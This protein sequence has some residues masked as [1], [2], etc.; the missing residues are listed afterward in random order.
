GVAIAVSALALW[1]SRTSLL[2]ALIMVFSAAMGL[3]LDKEPLRTKISLSSL[4]RHVI[5]Y[6]ALVS[7]MLKDTW[8]SFVIV[9]A[10]YALASPLWRDANLGLS[11]V[12]AFWVLYGTYAA[13][14]LSYVCYSQLTIGRRWS[15]RCSPFL[16][17]AA[18]TAH[19]AAA[20]RHELWAFFWG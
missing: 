16:E 13:V 4:P 12:A 20:R 5:D 9:F 18:N 8:F 19:P 7:G 3:A 11:T 14:R 17:H 1:G 6:C 10:I 15:A 2:V